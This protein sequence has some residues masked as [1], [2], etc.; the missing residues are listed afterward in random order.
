MLFLVMTGNRERALSHAGRDRT[1]ELS[2]RKVDLLIT[3]RWAP[4]ADDRL[5][6][7][8]LNDES[9]VIVAGAQNPLVRRRKMALAELVNESWVLPP[10]ES[11]FA[12]AVMEAFRAG[13]HDRPRTIAGSVADLPKLHTREH[14]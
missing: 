8:F 5:D 13:G 7:E 2:N 10:P 4:I 1:R 14:G 6:F 11:G 12:L 3:R 9:F